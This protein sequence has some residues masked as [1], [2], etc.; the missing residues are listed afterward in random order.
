[1]ASQVDMANLALGEI[2]QSPIT[3][4]DDGTRAANL[5]KAN[6]P[7]LLEAMLT[8][9]DWNF[10]KKRAQLAQEA[11]AP[12]F[13]FSRQFTL[14]ADC[15]A[16]RRI[17][18]D[19]KIPWKV[20]GKSLLTSEAAVN[21]EYTSYVDDVNQWSGMFRLGFAKLLASYLAGSLTGDMKKSEALLGQYT[22]LVFDAKAIDGQQGSA[23][24]GRVTALT[25]D[26]RTG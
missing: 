25:S 7:I 11:A 6:F 19:D 5:C 21:L 17:N 9:H 23:D 13:G 2:G 20:E 16:A 22:K 4:L 12:L 10:A 24:E 26:I 1:M 15:A 18:Q 3:S 8:D 14:P